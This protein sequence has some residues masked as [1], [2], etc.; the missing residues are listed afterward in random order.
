MPDSRPMPTIGHRCHEIRVSDKD[1][2]WRVIY[3]TDQDAILIGD[4]FQKKRSNT[5]QSV[6][7]NCRRR[8]RKYDDACR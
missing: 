8:F 7:E 2:W 3:R 5:P 4:V 1:S 6:I